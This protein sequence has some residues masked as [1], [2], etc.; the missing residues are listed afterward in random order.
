MIASSIHNHNHKNFL[1]PVCLTDLDKL[2]F[3]K[4][5]H[6]GLVF[7]TSPVALRNEAHFKNGQK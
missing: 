1:M 4:F 6:G 5:L 3:V 2:N 7:A